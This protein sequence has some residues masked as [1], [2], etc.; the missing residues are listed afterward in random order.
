MILLS[1]FLSTPSF[2]EIEMVE[3][4]MYKKLIKFF[5]AISLIS[6]EGTEI[7]KVSKKLS[8]N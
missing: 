4:F 2:K 8:F 5:S 6:S 3:S 7:F 1:S